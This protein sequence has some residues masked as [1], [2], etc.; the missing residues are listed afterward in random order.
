MRF[1]LFISDE[2]R[3]NKCEKTYVLQFFCD[4][5]LDSQVLVSLVALD[6]SFDGFD[7]VVEHQARVDQLHADQ[8]TWIHFS[9]P[10]RDLKIHLH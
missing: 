3:I 9:L 5:F 4:L 7:D 1:N 8:V 10:W 2:L 6:Q